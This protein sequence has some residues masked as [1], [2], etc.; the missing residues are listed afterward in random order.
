MN[1]NDN[2]REII[3]S[4][5]NNEGENTEVI[6]DIDFLD[7]DD[8]IELPKAQED[9]DFEVL[10]LAAALAASFAACS[11]ASLASSSALDSA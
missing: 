10:E 9:D 4:W 2:I 3:N 1:E 6:E 7:D 11:L 8:K 5:K